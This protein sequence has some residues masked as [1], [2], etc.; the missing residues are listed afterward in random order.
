SELSIVGS[1]ILQSYQTFCRNMVADNLGNLVA[2]I[3]MGFAIAFVGAVY[4]VTPLR[5]LTRATRQIAKGDFSCRMSVNHPDEFAR[6]GEAFNLMATGLQEGQRLKDFVSDSVRRE[7]AS[8]DAIEIAD[9][10]RIRHATIIFSAICGFS[11]F[12]KTHQVGEVFALLQQHLR[13]ADDAIS[14][15]GGEIDKMIEDKIM[16]VFEHD[17]PGPEISEKAIKLAQSMANAMLN[18]TDTQLGIGV[19]TGMIVAG[20]MG[21]ANARLA[22]TVVGDPVNL[23]ARLATLAVQR[24]GGGLIASQQVL[25][26]LPQS[27]T[28]EKLPIN[29]VKG[30]TQ[31]VEAYLLQKPNCQEILQKNGN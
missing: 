5:E 12:Q 20:V 23:A 24:P 30:K 9:R 10:A 22:R 27:F 26:G 21:A 6:T 7:I 28:A 3:I 1:E 16:I 14:Q 13:A 15:F 18:D 17:E 11:D 8:A 25:A 29:K 31:T 19:N 2:M 4:F